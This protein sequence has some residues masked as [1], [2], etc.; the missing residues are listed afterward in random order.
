MEDTIVAK[1]NKILNRDPDP[2]GMQTYKD[3]LKNR[4]EWELATVLKRSS[5]YAERIS[6][7]KWIY[8]FMCVRNN[9]KDL[10]QTF[11]TL[12]RIRRND[13][14]HE[15]AYFIFE[16]DSSDNTVELCKAFM[17]RNHGVFQSE[18]MNKKQWEDVKDIDR[19]TDMAVYRNRCKALCQ[20]I[21]ASEFCM[22]VDTKVSFSEN[23]C[24]SFKKALHDQSIAMVTPFGKVGKKP[25]YYD[26]Y[27]L[28]FKEKKRLVRMNTG[29]IDVLSA[30]GG[31]FMV[32][33]PAVV[34]AT[35]EG[36]DGNK[37]EH[38]AFCYS[39]SDFGRVVID[40]SVH[41]EW[42]K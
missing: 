32:R 8:V 18:I 13:E 42:V 38:N 30:C 19:V 4:K 20:D 21:S 36:I 22:L 23:I 11:E 7:K 24:E 15:Y 2:D 17:T 3:F 40:T 26:T 10:P 34:G 25:V 39:V 27:A 35:W 37:S 29:I 28:E 9:G 16:N 41:V 6:N 14:T 12:E 33:S 5:E 31:I 1:Y